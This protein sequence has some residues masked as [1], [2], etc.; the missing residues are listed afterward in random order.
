MVA[1]SIT[2]S[3]TRLAADLADLAATA[4]LGTGQRA[5]DLRNVDGGVANGGNG[6]NG[7][8]ADCGAVDGGGN[9]SGDVEIGDA[10]SGDSTTSTTSGPNQAG[11]GT[12]GDGTGGGSN[13]AGG[14][15]G[16]G[17]GGDATS[18]V[19]AVGQHVTG[20]G[21]TGGDGAGATGG[22]ATAGDGSGGNGGAAA[23]GDGTGG[24]GG[25]AGNGGDGGEAISGD[26]TGGDGGNAQVFS[27]SSDGSDV[28]PLYLG[29]CADDADFNCG[30]HEVDGDC[31]GTCV[32]PI[33]GD[34]TGFC[35]G[36]VTG[37]CTGVCVSGHHHGDH[38][39]H[40]GDHG[41]DGGDWNG[42]GGWNHGGHP[43]GETDNRIVRLH[44]GA[45]PP[46]T[47]KAEIDQ[48]PTGVEVSGARGLEV[49]SQGIA[50]VNMSA[51]DSM[52]SFDRRKCK[53][54]NGPTATGQQCQEG[55]TFIRNE[56]GPKFQGVDWPSDMLYLT[57]LR[58]AST[59]WALPAARTCR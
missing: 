26:A 15:G 17:Q 43:G 45:N 8:N 50:W 57:Q 40:D 28:E 47:C 18:E 14:T 55:V 52:A 58:T 6:G 38:D 16:N 51:T 31:T 12:G 23:G 19:S 54:L 30:K 5:A 48:V 21:N 35:F 53:V 39:G 36:K 3:A 44:F 24:D 29:L 27:T 49:D 25:N 34:C 42:G 37:D 22:T 32:G 2:S 4:R 20:G 13:A 33:Y 10:S 46:Q 1:R 41:D 56:T 9:T 59:R 7:G 11:N